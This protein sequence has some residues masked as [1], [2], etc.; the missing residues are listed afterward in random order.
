ML[1]L[2]TTTQYRALESQYKKAD[3]LAQELQEKVVNIES[4]FGSSH[5]LN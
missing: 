4:L 5:L 3:K 2:Y 1:G